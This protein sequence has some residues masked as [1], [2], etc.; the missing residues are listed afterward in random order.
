MLV[1]LLNFYNTDLYYFY[2]CFIL[3]M[4]MDNFNGESLKKQ[5]IKELESGNCGANLVLSGFAS[6]Y[7]CKN[8]KNN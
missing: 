7:S 2:D 1:L 5:I 3:L 8:E 4:K 6:I